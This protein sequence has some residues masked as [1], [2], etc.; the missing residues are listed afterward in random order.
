[1]GRVQELG[2]QPG[3]C[4][5]SNEVH[6]EIETVEAGSEVRVSEA[7]EGSEKPETEEIS[8]EKTTVP[9]E[10]AANRSGDFILKNAAKEKTKSN[11]RKKKED[12]KETL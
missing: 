7:E 9:G 6:E 11:T 12:D 5:T 3:R 4:R 1:M 8:R 10:K 2:G